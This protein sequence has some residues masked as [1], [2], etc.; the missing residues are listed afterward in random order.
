ML[1]TPTPAEI[2]SGSVTDHCCTLSLNVLRALQIGERIVTL[3]AHVR[4][5]PPETREGICYG[6][7]DVLKILHGTNIQAWAIEP[8]ACFFEHE[9]VLVLEGRAD[10]LAL[11]RPSITGILAFSTS[12]VTR[13]RNFV[14]AAGDK[15]IFFFGQR[16]L[17]PAHVRQYIECAYVAGMEI[18]TTPQALQ[19]VHSARLEDCG[20]HYANLIAD[21]SE[22]AWDAFLHL[23]PEDG[24][25]F[26]VLDNY[27][28]PVTEMRKAL[29][30]FGQQ[31]K[32]VLV[33]TDSSRRGN[34]EAIL[35]EIA[36]HLKVANRLDILLCLTG[37][38]TPE[39]VVRTSKHVSSY[40]VGL[41]ALNGPQFDFALQV[42]AVEHQPR[43]KI[44]VRPGRKS[45]FVCDR[46]GSRIVDLFDLPPTC[47][48]KPM[49]S[50]LSNV[51][52]WA[53][54]DL[55][56]VRKKIVAGA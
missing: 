43:S 49:A 27:D 56:D 54:I 39:L 16:K 22:A 48:G 26:I 31:L 20:E 55:A 53:P 38:V 50:Q 2:I 14:K 18:N 21:T 33:D 40:G 10:E 1:E 34:I 46:C 25:L 19:I 5:F 7:G 36:W 28:D 6:I 42:V 15:P 13:A 4:S 29:Q 44:G 37:G 30:Q 9:P 17:H 32:G 23:S 52:N 11:I 24:A 51:S 8:G 12:F 3:E 41:G 45:I 35:G 47:C